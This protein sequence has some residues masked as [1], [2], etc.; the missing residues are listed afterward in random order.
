MI[1]ELSKPLYVDNTMLQCFARCPRQYYWRH[2]RH[3]VPSTTG[4]S[5]ALNFGRAIHKALEERYKGQD[6]ESQLRS[7][8]E[9]LDPSAIDDKRN[10]ETGLLLLLDYDKKWGKEQWEVLGVEESLTF[11]LAKDVLFCARIDLRV[12]MMGSVYVV[13]HKT[14][15]RAGWFVPR[16]NHQ[17][18][19]YSYGGRL[20]GGEAEGAIVNILYVYAPSTKK[21]MNDKFHRA[22]THR[23]DIELEEWRHW[24]MWQKGLID[25]CIES[26]WFPIQ[27]NECFRCVYKDLC[28]TTNPE[29]LE[30][31][32][33]SSYKIEEWAPWKVDGEE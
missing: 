21:S 32:V 11:E 29:F 22:M 15:G 13:E 20:V 33:N 2:V 5:P 30:E 3:L 18:S 1:D 24:V 17:L 31:C 9:T 23:E 4:G 25:R 28:N 26:K 8:K 7:F 12:K 6:L 19:G 16:P 27:T 14:S 10:F